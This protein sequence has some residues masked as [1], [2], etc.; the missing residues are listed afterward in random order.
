M[1][2]AKL[3]E[4]EELGSNLLRV[5]QRSSKQWSERTEGVTRRRQPR[6]SAPTDRLPFSYAGCTDEG[7]S[8]HLTSS[9]E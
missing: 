9:S 8:P 2:S 3:A 1:A 7:G 6:L 5:D 4:G